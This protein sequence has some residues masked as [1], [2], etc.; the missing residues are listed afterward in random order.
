MS[1]DPRKN[2]CEQVE[3]VKLSK[4]ILYY[5]EKFAIVNELLI[6]KYHRI[7]ARDRLRRARGV[8]YK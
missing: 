8:V 1:R 5:F 4:K 3:H 6:I 2:F 7:S